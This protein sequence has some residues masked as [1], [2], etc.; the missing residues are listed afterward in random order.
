MT[1]TKDICDRLKLLDDFISSEVQ[2]YLGTYGRRT[3]ISD[4]RVYFNKSSMLAV[5]NNYRDSGGENL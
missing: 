5:Q 1:E 2:I 3:F 4:V